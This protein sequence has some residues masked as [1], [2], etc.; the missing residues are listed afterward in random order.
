MTTNKHIALVIGSIGMILDDI[1]TRSTNAHFI[2]ATTET[3]FIF[4][5]NE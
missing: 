4:S 5:F 2:L 3:A 1:K